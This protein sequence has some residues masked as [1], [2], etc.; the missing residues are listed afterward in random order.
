[1]SGRDGP[2]RAMMEALG[3]AG[4]EVVDAAPF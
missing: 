1:L 3:V 4:I 2:R